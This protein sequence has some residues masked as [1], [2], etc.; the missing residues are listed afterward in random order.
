MKMIREVAEAIPLVYTGTLDRYKGLRDLM[1]AS[2]VEPKQGQV[3]FIDKWSIK[4]AIESVDGLS[5]YLLEWTLKKSNDK[6]G[7][8]QKK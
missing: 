1:T 7:I 2:L 4:Q 8:V 3:T 6:A 5:Y